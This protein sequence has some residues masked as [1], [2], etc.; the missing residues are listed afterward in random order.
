MA[1]LRGSLCALVGASAL[2]AGCTAESDDDGLRSGTFA[3]TSIDLGNCSNDTWLKS[4]TTTS[5]IIVE[6]AGDKYV[7]R[8]CTDAG[9]APS[10]PSSFAWDVD[11]WRGE[12]GGAYLVED[13]CLVNYVNATAHL[14][15][16][17]LVIEASRWVSQLAGGSCTYDEVLA[18]GEGPCDSRTRLV[19]TEQ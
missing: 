9:C 18:M 19:A 10:S 16:G 17:E 14:V 7:V 4:S 13:G 5:S 12:D 2:L 6:G 3:V 8:T 15:D 1:V 11:S